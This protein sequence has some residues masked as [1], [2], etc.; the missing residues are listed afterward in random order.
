M[1]TDLSSPY[2][3]LIDNTPVCQPGIN[4]YKSLKIT[5]SL[6]G[7]HVILTHKMTIFLRKKTKKDWLMPCTIHPLFL[8]AQHQK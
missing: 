6:F 1:I 8:I 2:L 4:L 5:G 3:G 7:L